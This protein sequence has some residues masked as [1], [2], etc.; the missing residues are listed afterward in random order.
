MSGLWEK[1]EGTGK[2]VITVIGAEVS[3]KKTRK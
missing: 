2:K 3:K 1:V